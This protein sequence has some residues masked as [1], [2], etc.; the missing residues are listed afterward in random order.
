MRRLFLFMNVSLDG[1]FE[2]P[3]HDISFFNAR[4]DHFEPFSPEQGQE[5]DT[6]LFG[7]KTYGL[8]K[9]FWPKP[10]AAQAAPEIA[11]FMNENHKV[12]ASH[13]A[14]E[15]GWSKVT[16]ISNNVTGEV[17]KL[18]E[19]PGKNIIMFG[20]NN[21]CVSLMQAGLVDEF[22]ILVAPIAL[23]EGTSLFAGLSKRADLVLTETRQ[24]KSGKILLTYEP[25]NI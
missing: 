24:F 14:F 7:R 11:K 17:Q 19:Q 10:Q 15:P 12:V 1:Y 23:G 4:D 2:G 20:S 25:G 16:V 21:L 6:I 5:V 3:G 8:M 22:Q 9:A 13:R 18:K